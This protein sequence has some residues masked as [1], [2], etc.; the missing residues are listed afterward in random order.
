MNWWIR[1]LRSFIVVNRFCCAPILLLSSISCNLEPHTIDSGAIPSL[2][3]GLNE[4]TDGGRMPN[5]SGLNRADASE[6]LDAGP[7]PDAHEIPAP[8]A[9]LGA[10]A[11]LDAGQT[12]PTD[13][14][15]PEIPFVTAGH[16]PFDESGNTQTI[17]IDWTEPQQNVAIRVEIESTS[18]G[19]TP[20][21]FVSAYQPGRS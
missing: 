9:G 16:F 21:E 14:G 11:G 5:D 8:D 4:N 13:S 3:A 10:D 12:S 19:E 1:S 15:P 17:S 6:S 18:G 20:C 2:D 7:P